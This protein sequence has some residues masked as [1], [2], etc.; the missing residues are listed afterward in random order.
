MILYSAE[1]PANPMAQ[2]LYL[3]SYGESQRVS[4][5]KVFLY[6]VEKQTI[7]ALET[8]PD[9]YS[10][11]ELSWKVDG[12]GII[13]TVWSNHPFPMGCPACANRKSQV[14]NEKGD[15]RS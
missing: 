15:S 11:G 14:R 2:Y 1:A 8:I 5:P 4:R 10:A 7:L 3:G 9:F 6:D 12:S 13:G